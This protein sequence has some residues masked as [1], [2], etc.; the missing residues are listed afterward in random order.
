[1]CICFQVFPDFTCP[2]CCELEEENHR[3]LCIYRPAAFAVQ[4]SRAG[5]RACPSTLACRTAERPSLAEGCCSGVVRVHGLQAGSHGWAF[6]RSAVDRRK[7]VWCGLSERAF[8]SELVISVE[9]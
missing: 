9:V 5:C 8:G 7:E 4:G 2:L 1:M 6:D 3:V